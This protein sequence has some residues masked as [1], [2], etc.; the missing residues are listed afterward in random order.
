VKTITI[1]LPGELFPF[2]AVG[3]TEEAARQFRLAAAIEWYREG[4]VSQGRGVEIAGLSRVDF[5]DALYRAKVPACQVTVDELME[6]VDSAVQTHRQCI[7]ADPSEQG[8]M[9]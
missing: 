6:E 5:L 4:R 8:R 1:E 3:S 2:P 7:A 9:P